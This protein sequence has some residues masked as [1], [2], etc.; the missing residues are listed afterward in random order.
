MSNNKTRRIK[1]SPKPNKRNPDPPNL[2]KK[3][4]VFSE[5]RLIPQFGLF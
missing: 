2:N 5:L 1:K 3:E 4:S